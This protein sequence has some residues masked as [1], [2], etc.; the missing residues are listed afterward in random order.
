MARIAAKP[1]NNRYT[2]G[3]G[4]SEVIG[5]LINSIF[6]AGIIIFLLY[7]GIDRILNP[8]E[9]ESLGVILIASG[10]LIVNIIAIY[11]LKDS[12]SLNSKAAPAIHVI[13]DF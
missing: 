1:A 3:H 9:V 13:G 4:R 2:Y 10:G 5:A 6:M 11:L 7:K 8:K 12:H